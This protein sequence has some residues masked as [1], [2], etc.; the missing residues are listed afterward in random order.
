MSIIQILIGI[1]L[2]H[3]IILV[4]FETIKPS[5]SYFNAMK[6]EKRKDNSNYFRVYDAN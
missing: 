3:K 5:V 1:K 6:N 2:H 4:D